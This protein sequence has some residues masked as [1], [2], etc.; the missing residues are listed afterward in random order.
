MSPSLVAPQ[1]FDVIKQNDGVQ[2]R[3][4]AAAAAT[5][6]FWNETDQFELKLEY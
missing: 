3:I 5:L 4:S 6:G 1:L 2:M